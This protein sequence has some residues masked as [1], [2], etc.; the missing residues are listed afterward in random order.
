MNSDYALK[1]AKNIKSID[2]L[3]SDFDF[4]PVYTAE[5]KQVK[6]R[7]DLTYYNGSKIAIVKSK[8]YFSQNLF[9]E[10]GELPEELPETSDPT[11]EPLIANL[12]S[13]NNR[14]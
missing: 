7:L 14:E 3:I 10:D 2:D 8:N 1:V 13:E 6:V 11:K 9:S 4:D 12:P 5:L